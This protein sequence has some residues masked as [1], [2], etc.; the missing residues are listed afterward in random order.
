MEDQLEQEV[1]QAIKIGISKQ[2]SQK[3]IGMQP[4]AV[5]RVTSSSKEGF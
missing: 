3:R 5:T 4:K 2:L 1:E